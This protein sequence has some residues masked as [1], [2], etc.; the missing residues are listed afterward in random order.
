MTKRFD[1]SPGAPVQPSS[2]S[3]KPEGKIGWNKLPTG[4]R[5]RILWEKNEGKIYRVEKSGWQKSKEGGWW[6][7]SYPFWGLSKK[8]GVPLIP[9]FLW[10][11]QKPAGF[12]AVFEM[13]SFGLS[14]QNS[15]VKTRVCVNISHKR[16][17]SRNSPRR[18]SGGGGIYNKQIK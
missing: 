10:F 9:S 18:P 12:F 4:G 16:K 2:S 8:V 17:Y 7:P 14:A 3:K 15:G 5:R 13:N 11:P 1:F 6:P